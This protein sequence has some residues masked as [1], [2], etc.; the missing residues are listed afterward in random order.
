[1][2]S[3]C[4]YSGLPKK[5]VIGRGHFFLRGQPWQEEGPK[6]REWCEQFSRRGKQAKSSGSAAKKE[7]EG[8]GSQSELRAALGTKS[9]QG[10]HEVLDEY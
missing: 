8:T 7:E 2:G 3:V 5:E 4:L 9:S 10:Y 1:M 6:G